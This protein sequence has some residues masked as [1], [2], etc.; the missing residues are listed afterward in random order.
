MRIHVFTSCIS[1][2]IE[3]ITSEECGH[4]SLESSVFNWLDKVP[5]IDRE[6]DAKPNK[7]GNLKRK[8]HH[9]VPTATIGTHC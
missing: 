3:M 9:L 8:R 4:R 1:T 5:Q 6:C 7:K 2:L